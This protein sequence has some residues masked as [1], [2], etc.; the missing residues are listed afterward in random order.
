VP[1]R[2]VRRLPDLRQLHG[3]PLLEASIGGNNFGRFDN[4]EFEDLIAKAQAETDDAKPAELYNQAEEILLNEQ[5]HAVPLNFYT[6]SQV[7]RD[8]VKNY[9][10]APLGIMLWERMAV[11]G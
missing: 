11:E 4:P 9:D 10:H 2:L 5:T 6:G 1:G 7:F 3:R 8:R